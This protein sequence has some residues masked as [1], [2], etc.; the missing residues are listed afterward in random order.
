MSFG[1]IKSMVKM[2]PAN[3]PY[4]FL[5][6]TNDIAAQKVTYPAHN[7]HERK[8]SMPIRN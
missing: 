6:F 2:C 3:L 7:E 4:Y 8:W 5:R 1:A